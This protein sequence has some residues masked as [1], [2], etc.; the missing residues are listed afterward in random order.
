MLATASRHE[1][2]KAS[3]NRKGGC[4]SAVGGTLV[5]VL[6]HVSTLGSKPDGFF[7]KHSPGIPNNLGQYVIDMDD[8]RRM[9]ITDGCPLQLNQGRKLVG[10][11]ARSKDNV[12][13]RLQH[14]EGRSTTDKPPSPRV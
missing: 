11:E 2:T 8:N 4:L 5:L 10:C 3:V 7:S 12:S 14:S 9:P 1:G 13:H 6:N